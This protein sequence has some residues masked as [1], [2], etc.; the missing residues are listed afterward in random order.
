MVWLMF[1]AVVLQNPP[2]ADASKMAL[3]IAEPIAELDMGK[4]KGEPARL[5]WSPDKMEFYVQ[6]AERDGHG[7]VKSAKHYVV[8]AASRTVRASIENRSGRR[9]TGRGNRRRPRRVAATFK[10]AVDGP[11][12]ESV[13][14]T[15]APAGGA[16]AKGGSANRSKAR[17]SPTSPRRSIN[18]RRGRSTR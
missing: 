13:R 9:S 10:I 17:P 6:T 14:A 1:A 5:A 4:M 15:S 18:R 16:L 12:Q 3:S 8:S 7:A 2:A 11:R